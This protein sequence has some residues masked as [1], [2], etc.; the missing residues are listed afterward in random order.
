MW[1]KVAEKF[2]DYPARLSVARVLVECGLCVCQDATIRCGGV[3]V[4]EV[5]LAQAA[6]VDR[7][8]V[9][10]TVSA[11]LKDKALSRIFENVAPAG[12]FLKNVAPLLGFGVVEIEAQAEKSG[13]IAG[14][15]ALLAQSRISIRQIHADDPQLSENPKMT[16]ITEK[17]VAGSL[18]AK[19]LKI[20]GVKKVSIS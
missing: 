7:R 8:A 6:K 19:F 12:A 3:E 18:V 5:S 10:A 15:T 13:I 2:K 17:P 14:A 16:I 4:K 20:N 1:D 9:G 11:I